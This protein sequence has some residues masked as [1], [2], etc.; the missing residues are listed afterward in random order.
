MNIVNLEPL[1]A[2]YG[3]EL[4]EGSGVPDTKPTDKENVITK[5]LGVL[6]E[7]GIYAMTIFLM[8]SNSPKYSSHVLIKLAA[9]LA[10]DN[11]N[12]MKDCLKRTEKSLP[13][14][15][16]ANPWKLLPN[17]WWEDPKI[18]LPILE[19]MRDI[20]KELP[21]LLLAR[22][23]LEETMTFARYHCKALSRPQGA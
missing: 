1:C 8:T 2:F 14:N 5:A 17:K 7:K 18:M 12:L 11:I 13:K 6:V 4:V 21:R 23:V 15:W 16:W 3:M 9:L 22:K 20:T 10:D 19:G